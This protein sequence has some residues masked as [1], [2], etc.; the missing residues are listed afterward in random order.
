M[1][2]GI[3]YPLFPVQTL[4]RDRGLVMAD[5]DA[6]ADVFISHNA[7]DKARFVRQLVADLEQA[8]VSCWLDEKQIKP[9]TLIP[10]AVGKGLEQCRFV[11]IVLSQHS[12]GSNWVAFERDIA[13]MSLLS[14]S[15]KTIIPILLEDCEPPFI[16]RAIASADFVELVGAGI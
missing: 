12:T 8:G 15:S 13:L 3:C 5:Q 16:L 1:L 7:G 4:F 14:D 10:S 6:F 9:G 2:T 11:V